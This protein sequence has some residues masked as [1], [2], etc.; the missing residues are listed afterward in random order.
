VRL[1]QPSVFDVESRSTEILFV[2]RERDSHRHRQISWS[3]AQIVERE[4]R[5]RSRT[6]S[7]HALRAPPPHD[8][9]AFERFQRAQQYGRGRSFGFSDGI[10]EGMN[11]VVEVDVR[12]SGP[13]V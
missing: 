3:S 6:P 8:V 10:D 5:L 4:C 9:H 13:A 11:A 12:E 2:L 7:F 1:R